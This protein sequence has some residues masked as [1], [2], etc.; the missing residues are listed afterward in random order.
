MMGGSACK[1]DTV[2]A[3]QRCA[4]RGSQ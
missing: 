4:D 2:D 1:R 3:E